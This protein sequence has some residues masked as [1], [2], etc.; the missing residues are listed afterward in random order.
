LLELLKLGVPV[1]IR[2]TNWNKAPQWPGL[3]SAWK[4]GPVR[5]DDYAKAIQCAKVNVGLLSK[6]NRDLH[7]TRSLEIPALGGLLCAERSSEHLALYTEGVEALFWSDADRCAWALTHEVERQRIAAAGQRRNIANRIRNETVISEI[8]TRALG[9]PNPDEA[10]P[11]PYARSNHLPP[12][13]S[14]HS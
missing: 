6:G 13:N 9:E 10:A 4:S 12:E 7:T 2:G 3:K 5:G 11:Q 14:T 1:T 8:L